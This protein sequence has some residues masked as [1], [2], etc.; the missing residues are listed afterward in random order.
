M[1][2]D[3][4][5]SGNSKRSFNS[6]SSNNTNNKKKNTNQKT[7]GAAWGANSLSSSRSSFGSA[8]FSDFGSYMAVKNKKL[9][10][11]FDAE[12]SNSTHSGSDSVK[13][14]FQGVSIFVDGF[15]IPS[16]Q[17]L[18]AYMLKHG[19]RVENYFS[20]HR[21]THI[22]CS[23]LPDSKIKNLRSFSGG[24]PVVKPTWVLDCVA[25]RKLLNWVPYQLDQLVNEATNQP[26]LSAFFTL[27]RNPASQV[28]LSDSTC[29]LQAEAEGS[30]VRDGDLLNH[31]SSDSDGFSECSRQSQKVME[32]DRCK[33]FD[34]ENTLE[35]TIGEEE[36]S[37]LE[38]GKSVDE[39]EFSP[40]NSHD[41]Y[42]KPSG[43]SSGSL[44][45]G[46]SCRRN[47]TLED[48]NFVE[49]YFK[50]SRLHF[51]G[52]WRNRYRK[53]FACPSN[54][55]K[56]KNIDVNASST[57]R[58]ATI[59]HMDMD[60]FFVAVVIRNRPELM[61][62]PVAVCHSDSP[63]GTSEISSA[64]YP[65]RDY[66]VK[67]GMFVRD[68]KARCPH[69]EIV[70]YNFEAYE[71]AVSCDEAFLDVTDLEVAEPELLVSEIRKEIFETT[72]CTA[73]AGIAANMLMAR[74]ATRTAKPNG[75][76]YISPEKVDE[77]LLPLPIKAL[78]GI[79]HVLEQKLKKKGVQT[80][81]QLRMFPKEALQ[82]DFGTK[83]GEMLWNY[84][85]GVDN[86]L[87]GVIQESKSIGADVN[88][89]VRFKDV[90]DS[91]RF[92]LSLCKEVSLRLQ[93]CGL[94][95]RTF[96][97]KIKK[98]I[99][100]AGEP[101]KYMG[102][103]ACENLS[104]STTVPVA[105]DDVEILQRKTLQ[106]FGSF[107]I[108][109]KDI[110]GIGLQVTKLES[111]D[112]LKQGKERNT[113]RSWLGSGSASSN[114][115]SKVR[116][117]GQSHLELA[118]PSA[119]V[120]NPPYH[121]THLNPGVALPSLDDLD[122]GVIKSLPPE[123]FS[124]INDMYGGKLTDLI[125]K[126]KGKAGFHSVCSMPMEEVEGELLHEHEV[127]ASAGVQTDNI[128]DK[129][130]A[131]C[132]KNQEKEVLPAIGT[133]TAVISNSVVESEIV[134]LMPYSLSQVDM[135][136]L[137]QLPEEL[138]ADIVG[139]LPSHRRPNSMP[140]S[141]NVYGK[142]QEVRCGGDDTE[143]LECAKDNNLWVGSPPCWVHKFKVSNCLM[144]N[145]LAE[146]FLR[147]RSTGVL[148]STLQ[149]CL[150]R[151]QTCND[152]SD[153]VADEASYSLCELLRQ[154]IQLKLEG[155]I[156]EIYVCFRLLKRLTM[157]SKTFKHAYDAVLPYLQA[158]I[159]EG[160]GGLFNLPAM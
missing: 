2:H 142:V 106:L 118:G 52:T 100:D 16:S 89:G 134:D 34:T 152:E 97:L 113:L 77:Y 84:S 24:L 95:G 72:G 66:G 145:I 25:A 124:E 94:H 121:Q 57:S 149:C 4:T 38:N 156:E 101:T 70:P 43:E 146:M 125:S 133:S 31:A 3:V 65:A 138:R 90:K 32:D 102:H 53:R 99:K 23:N 129:D 37:Q 122:L 104:H 108:D 103:G 148:S 64:N 131:G 45:K 115:Q 109:V 127:R 128:N 30:D 144:L 13:P 135:S 74:L 123:L 143:F 22:I 15:T 58:K 71:E 68:A 27:K 75:Q 85:R 36:F 98:R 92:L 41:L 126:M 14:I 159:T 151:F 49:N 18:R 39:V 55:M 81:G 63:R 91:E 5:R 19:G 141:C 73:S 59:I 83:T 110:R 155:D 154:Y 82:R 8:P 29:M 117:T 105:T 61:D 153:D 11:Q 80:C 139:A 60:C 17:E 119:M 21:V 87:V 33:Q 9:H 137:H 136:I 88:W 78:P 160:Y 112:T 120:S 62:K 158:C 76:C 40:T 86:R 130:K 150:S 28:V 42:T 10:E 7:L 93:G 107:H 111:V 35:Q 26:K 147:S 51:I 67:A 12:A 116:D 50:S 44:V 20:R 54:K 132:S 96:T 6:N 1:S 47:S 79:G 140:E 46:S 157:K 48:P 56:Q 69:L 114:E